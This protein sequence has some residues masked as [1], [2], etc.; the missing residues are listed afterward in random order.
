MLP[1]W[2][3][4]SAIF[5]VGYSLECLTASMHQIWS[6]SVKRLKRY[7]DL[8]VFTMAADAIL[9]FQKL[10]FLTADTLERPNLRNPAKFHQDR[11]IRMAIFRLFKIAT[12]RH[13]GNLKIAIV[14]VLCHKEYQCTSSRQISSK[15][16]K[17]LKRYRDL[18]V[19]Q[20]G[21]RRHLA[22]STVKFLNSWYAWDTQSA[23]PCRILSRSVDPFL[24]YGDLSI[25]QDG[26][27]P[28]SWILKSAIFR[29]GAVQSSHARHLIK[30]GRNRSNGCENITI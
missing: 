20:N 15:S 12:V 9:D 13:L 21:G 23:W 10:K 30:F 19:F 29:F 1:S 22:L 2:I 26:R 24:G 28:P 25:F 14:N 8:T 3:L 17:R 11:S 5:K 18:T 7:R 4:N 16:V 27:R 6:K